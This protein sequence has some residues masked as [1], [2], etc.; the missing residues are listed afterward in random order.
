MIRKIT[1]TG[2]GYDPALG[3]SVRDP[4]LPESREE[5][6]RRMVAD[7]TTWPGGRLCMKRVVSLQFG[8]IHEAGLPIVIEGGDQFNRW[9]YPD[10]EALLEAGWRVD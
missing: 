9:S 4:T 1:L 6:V 3:K 10:L 2:T 7:P 5:R 8:V